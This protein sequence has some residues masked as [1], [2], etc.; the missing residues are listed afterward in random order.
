MNPWRQRRSHAPAWQEDAHDHDRHST[1]SGGRPWRAHSVGTCPHRCRQLGD[2]HRP[3]A[4]RAP[5][6]RV[7]PARRPRGGGGG[8]AA[9][10][11]PHRSRFLH[12][13]VG[14]HRSV[15]QLVPGRSHRPRRGAARTRRVR[16]R[17]APAAR[18][19]G[20]R[21][22]ADGDARVLVLARR[23]DPH[24]HRLRPQRRPRRWRP[25]HG[26]PLPLRL[27]LV[28]HRPR[29]GGDLGRARRCS[30]RGR[31]ACASAARRC[32]PGRRSWASSGR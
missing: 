12:P 6:H 15:V 3:Q 31:P 18:R 20:A 22:P 28:C 23:R 25:A 26:R 16:G 4:D 5:V 8:R 13:V 2:Q 1:G 32:S 27:G 30:R 14:Q 11:R 29:A 19:P 21:L 17:R 9:R 10:A 24:D 7:Q